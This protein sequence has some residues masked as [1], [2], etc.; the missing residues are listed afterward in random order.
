MT[1][2]SAF[3]DHISSE[4]VASAKVVVPLVMDLIHP[5]SVV[6]V[7]C[8]TGAWLRTFLEL[9]VPSVLGLDSTEVEQSK[10]LI[11]S[12]R[13]RIIDLMKPFRLPDT[14]DLALSLEVAEHLPGPSA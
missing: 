11:P 4:A 10:L 7:G 14:Y 8:A 6:D 2:S 1:Y 5:T 13:F 9:G 3:Y 12:D